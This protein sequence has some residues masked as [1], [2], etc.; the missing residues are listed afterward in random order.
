M[1]GEIWYYYTMEYCLCVKKGDKNL[2]HIIS[3]VDL[4]KPYYEGFALLARAEFEEE[5]FE[6]AAQMVRDFCEGFWIR[7]LSPDFGEFKAWAL[8]GVN[9]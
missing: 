6:M 2:L 4:D 9:K 1:C 3:S 5:A 7:G 8:D